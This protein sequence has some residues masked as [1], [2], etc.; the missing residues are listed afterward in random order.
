MVYLCQLLAL[1][2]Y[3]P[4]HVLGALVNLWQLPPEIHG[5]GVGINASSWTKVA[6]LETGEFYWAIF[7][8]YAESG[9][10]YAL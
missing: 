10:E 5:R 6:A 4:S 2:L 3:R 1:L 8:G 7:W 9:T